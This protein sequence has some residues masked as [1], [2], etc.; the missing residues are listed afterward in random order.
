M[1]VQR[2]QHIEEVA[3]ASYFYYNNFNSWMVSVVNR[4]LN[5]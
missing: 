2:Q 1:Q 4:D 3:I 5:D